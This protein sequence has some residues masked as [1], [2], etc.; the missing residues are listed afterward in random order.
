MRMLIK[1]K[2]VLTGEVEISSSKNAI[3]PILAASLLTD[4]KVE[5]RKVPNINDV[6]IITKLLDQLGTKTKHYRNTLMLSGE[7]ISTNP[8]Y[9]LVRQIRASVLI[10]GPLLA[11]QGKVRVALPGG[12][13]DWHQTH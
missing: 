1:G 3:L 5:I 13:C 2:T 10:M 6:V 7:S 4:D 12:M 8:P 9:E 11:R